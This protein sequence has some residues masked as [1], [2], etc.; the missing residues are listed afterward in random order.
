MRPF[1]CST[2]RTWQAWG[3]R[4]RGCADCGSLERHRA[5]A[6]LLPAV[7]ELVGPGLCVDVAPATCLDPALDALHTLQVVRVDLDPAADGRIVDVRASVTH[8]PFPDGSAQLAMCSHVLEHV[9]DDRGA[10][11]ELRRVV[12]DTGL[13]LV[14]VPRRPGPTDEDPDAPTQERVRR[15]GQADHV[16]YYGD[17]FEAR[18]E[19]AGLAHRSLTVGEVLPPETVDLCRLIGSERVWLVRRAGTAP[20]PTVQ[21]VA[22]VARE[23]AGKAGE[24]AWSD[25]GAMTAGLEG[26]AARIDHL[27]AE[28]GR[29]SAQVG[30]LNGRIGQLQEELRAARRA[31]HRPLA[32]RAANRAR[33]DA[34]RVLAVVRRTVTS[35][36]AQ[37]P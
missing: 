24:A 5:F 12:S 28:H 6:L 33:R 15:F 10:M 13:A 18:L 36:G 22:T 7:A 1:F 11:R 3:V 23:T 26:A 19:E 14:V 25:L 8:L 16:R 30:A 21:D 27:T 34:R 35:S 20:L 29:L 32:R 4:S 9:P 17:D 2:C 31:V 37:R